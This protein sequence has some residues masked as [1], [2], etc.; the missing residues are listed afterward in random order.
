MPRTEKIFQTEI[1]RAFNHLCACKKI[2]GVFWKYPDLGFRTPFDC[3]M[4]TPGRFVACELKI[5]KSKN[6]FNFKTMFR[7]R[8]HQI[9]NLRQIKA[10]FFRAYLILNHFT[11]RGHNEV[12]A[13]DIDTANRFWNIG[14]VN[15][16][17]I[18]RHAIVLSKIRNEIRNETI[19]DLEPLLN[20]KQIQM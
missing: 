2:P 6:I 9:K 11:G 14:N 10:C 18:K 12:Y 7:S 16:D 5:V 13:L 1:H 8:L 19:F 4:I 3:H 20:G 15:L 17:T